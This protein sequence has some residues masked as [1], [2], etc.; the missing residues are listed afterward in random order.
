MAN[1]NSA[2][3]WRPA[4]VARVSMALHAAG[5]LALLV[6]PTL[7]PWVLATLAANHLLLTFAVLWPRGRVLGPNLVRLPAVAIQ[8]G[9]ISLTFD[10]GPDAEITP[11]VLDLL[12]RYQARASFFVIGKKAAALP[13]VIKEIVRRGHSVEN[14]SHRHA[15]TFAFYGVG[16][17]GREVEFCQTTIAA[18]AGRPARFFRAPAGFRSALLD[19]VLAK[20]GLRYA[21]WTRRGFD[22]VACDPAKVLQRLCR[23]LAAGDILLLHDG[24]GTRTREGKSVVL[25]VLP[26]LLD[27]IAARG[28]K[29]VPLPIA[30][31]LEP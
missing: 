15:H 2:L 8:R 11:Q 29:S 23:D 31:A 9:E 20:R 18:L 5:A 26:L 16:R 24:A 10:D 1:T 13:D 7:W 22:G 25:A 12:D 28:L 30:C 17:L 19:P 21:S 6:Q 3:R 4:L 14:H 27:Q